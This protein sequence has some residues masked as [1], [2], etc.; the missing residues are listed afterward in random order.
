MYTGAYQIPPPTI[1]DSVA[2]DV[3]MI[4]EVIGAGE[5]AISDHRSS[6]PTVEELARIATEA[7]VGGMLGGKAGIV[8]IHMG[9]AKD[10]FR[11]IYE[12][13]ANNEIGF[14]QFLPTHI[15]RNNYIFEDAKSYGKN[16]VVDITSSSYPYFP[17]YEIKPAHAVAQL[18]KS[19]VPLDNI[20]MSSDAGGSL[21]DFDENGVLVKLES[22]K[23]VSLLNEFRD[24]IR[25][26]K[27][28]IADAIHVVSTNVARVL[29]LAN[30][31][32]ISVS[33]D[34]DLLVLD[35]DLEIFA[36]I[37]GGELITRNYEIVK[38]TYFDKT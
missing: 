3:A 9:D 24:M 31:G 34:A 38:K 17:E 21:P 28:S 10:P 4:E 23:P 37:A 18:L 8:N 20:T 5:I 7:R 6:A 25:N 36:M 33:S 29:K 27:I 32:T 16:G 15:N 30:K 35:K 2:E 11:P 22:G 26:E 13:V 19:G 12:V 14:N 1:L